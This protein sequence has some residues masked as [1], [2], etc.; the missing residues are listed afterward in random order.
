MASWHDCY[1]YVYESVAIYGIPKAEFAKFY[2]SAAF[3]AS[4]V[5]QAGRMGLPEASYYRDRIQIP[6]LVTSGKEVLSAHI[7]AK[8][9]HADA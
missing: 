9:T 6:P 2:V 7:E 1:L 5:I 4:K 3:S 8:N